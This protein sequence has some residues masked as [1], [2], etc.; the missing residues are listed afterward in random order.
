MLKDENNILEFKNNKWKIKN[1]DYS[2]KKYAPYFFKDEL[3]LF[4][5]FA[6]NI[7][8]ERNPK[9]DLESDKRCMANIYKKNTKYSEFLRKSVAEVLPIIT[10]N[11]K[12]FKNCKK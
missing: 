9:F 12:E 6:I 5:T 2:I 11:Y 10:S 1:R 4:K 3:D 8:S 7:L